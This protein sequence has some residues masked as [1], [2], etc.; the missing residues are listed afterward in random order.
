M[1][2]NSN[3]NFWKNFIFIIYEKDSKT[4]RVPTYSNRGE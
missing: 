4:N 3:K 2:G 1:R